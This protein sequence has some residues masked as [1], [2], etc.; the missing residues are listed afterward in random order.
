MCPDA[1]GD[2]VRLL[3]CGLGTVMLQGGDEGWRRYLTVMLDGLR[4]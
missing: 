4:A 3:M 2:D 1:T